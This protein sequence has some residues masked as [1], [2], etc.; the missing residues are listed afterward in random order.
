MRKLSQA[1]TAIKDSQRFGYYDVAYIHLPFG[2]DDV[3]P[4]VLEIS[5]AEIEVL[6]SLD[7]T[8]FIYKAHTGALGRPPTTAERA[9][10]LDALITALA[11]SVPA[12]KAAAA[13]LIDGL[14]A[15]GEYT[16]LMHN[17]DQFVTDLYA[18]YLGRIADKGKADWVTQVGATDR[19]TV[20]AAFRESIEFGKRV[21]LLSEPTPHDNDI[22]EM[23][24]L[25]FSDGASIDG[26]QF[27]LT[28]AE[29]TYSD[30]LGEPGR[31]LYPAPATVKR[32]FHLPDGT[33]EAV[34]MLE[35]FAQFGD[36]DGDKASVTI[37]ADTSPDGTDVV[38]E[39]TQ[40]CGN[41][42]KRS[43]CDS[44]D[45]SATCSHI[46]FDAV[47][48]CISKLP[49]PQIIDIMPLNNLP[50]FKG[51]SKPLIVTTTPGVGL[52]PGQVGPDGWPIDAYDPHDPLR[53]GARISV[54]GL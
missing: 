34:V 17:D 49:A 12:L 36:V 47:N 37:V 48:G 21:S 45:P 9:A 8:E 50:R 24:D 35:G 14:F 39:I 40:H 7:F 19:A 29:N 53:K 54:S 3:L 4:I 26:V 51:I 52:D 1:V 10:W 46:K 30:L 20:Q 22:R 43:G 33:Y 5:T 15:S 23:G 32:A 28:N 27:S 44:A 38:E 11:T 18:A 6:P 41:I 16:A 13:D 31:R 2:P 25:P 42:Y